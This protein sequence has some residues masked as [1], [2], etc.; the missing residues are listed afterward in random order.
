MYLSNTNKLI[1]NYYIFFISQGSTNGIV[2]TTK[3]CL[4]P[5]WPGDG[6]CD[7]ET[8]NEICEWDGGDCCGELVKTDHCKIC[9]CF[10]P[11]YV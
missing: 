2:I 6:I 11:N 3:V 4:K 1:A 10:D 8:N 7:D 5:D 9:G